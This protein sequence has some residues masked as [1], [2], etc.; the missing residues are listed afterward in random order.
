M[1]NP[2]IGYDLDQP[3]LT[4]MAELL[5]GNYIATNPQEEAQLRELAFWRWVAFK[6]YAGKPPDF[7]REHQ[8]KLMLGCYGKTGW[9]IDQFQNGSV[10]E[11]GCGPFRMI[12][13]IPGVQL[14]AY[15]PLNDEYGR[16]FAKL[17]SG[18]INY[19]SDSNK[20]AAIPEVDFGICFNVLDHTEDARRWFVTFFERIKHGGA[21]LL[22]VNTVREDLERT[23]EHKKMHPSPL[24]VNTVLHWLSEVSADYDHWISEAPSPDNE[25]FFI[26]WGR[27]KKELGV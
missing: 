7:F 19:F 23:E 24:N 15:D 18:H 13:F 1:T 16:L 5:A 11:L 20:L 12:E 10:F 21:F 17:R 14:Y 6:G 3:V 2:S 25:F 27:K 22:S 9:P 4:K 8:K 26:A